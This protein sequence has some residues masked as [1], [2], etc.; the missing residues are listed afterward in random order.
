M[1][2]RP[3]NGGEGKRGGGTGCVCYNVRPCRE[4]AIRSKTRGNMINLVI[5]I[6]PYMCTCQPLK[7]NRIAV[8]FGNKDSSNKNEKLSL[9]CNFNKATK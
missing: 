2:P 1:T 3:R 7:G 5:K 9:S 4:R 8:D 6:R